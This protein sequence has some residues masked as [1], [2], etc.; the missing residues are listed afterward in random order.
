[1]TTVLTT[2]ALGRSIYIEGFNKEISDAVGE[3]SCRIFG[4]N[5][6][7][8]DLDIL[9]S[10]INLIEHRNLV[11][12]LDDLN[13]ASDTHPF[14]IPPGDLPSDATQFSGRFDT[15]QDGRVIVSNYVVI[16]RPAIQCDTPRCVLGGTLQ[17]LEFVHDYRL[18]PDQDR[19]DSGEYCN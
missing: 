1:M 2:H 19:Y 8:V 11:L 18:E 17:F 15:T 16:D 12:F 6:T 5:L 4:L 3:F 10:D 14:L 7:T 9:R 13:N